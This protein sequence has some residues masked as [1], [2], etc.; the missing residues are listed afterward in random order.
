MR[1]RGEPVAVAERASRERLVLQVVRFRRLIEG[2][3][4]SLLWRLQRTPTPPQAIRLRVERLR[5]NLEQTEA[6]FD[7][8]VADRKRLFE[9]TRNRLRQVEVGLDDE[10]YPPARGG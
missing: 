3:F 10:V 5:E 6:V 1:P 7:A 4:P 9:L 8:W 2:L